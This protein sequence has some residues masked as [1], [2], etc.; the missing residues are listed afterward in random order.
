MHEK[1]IV[2]YEFKCNT[3]HVSEK[4]KIIIGTFWIIVVILIIGWIWHKNTEVN[5]IKETTRLVDFATNSPSTN[6]TSTKS[7]ATTTCNR[8]IDEKEVV[9]IGYPAINPSFATSSIQWKK[10][11]DEKDKVSFEY[12]ADMDV[13]I[14]IPSIPDYDSGN[15]Y[16]PYSVKISFKDKNNFVTEPKPYT[17][18][19]IYF[20]TQSMIQL[21]NSGPVPYGLT[22]EESDL[23]SCYSF[24][25]IIPDVYGNAFN[26]LVGYYKLGD[27]LFKMKSVLCKPNEEMR[28]NYV[29]EH[30]LGSIEFLQ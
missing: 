17:D 1:L 7:V 23:T 12:P 2:K 3:P 27:K 19:A 16:I 24:K 13:T 18:N 10:F 5:N 6:S 21:T 25:K 4:I 9:K 22:A 29:F 20:M 28:C 26:P 8:Y 15:M 11:V 30:V 14:L